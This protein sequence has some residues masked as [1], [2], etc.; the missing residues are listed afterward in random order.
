MLLSGILIYQSWKLQVRSMG[1]IYNFLISTLLQPAQRSLASKGKSSN[2]A[3]TV[4]YHYLPIESLLTVY[5]GT[6]WYF[7]H[8]TCFLLCRAIPSIC[9]L[10]STPQDAYHSSPEHN[11]TAPRLFRGH[12]DSGDLGQRAPG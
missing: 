7:G 4:R 10:S 3:I 11:E 12:L 2:K 1:G 8:R 5:P 6:D 9:F